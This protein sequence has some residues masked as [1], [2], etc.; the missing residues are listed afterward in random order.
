MKKLKGELFCKIHGEVFRVDEIIRSKRRS[1]DHLKLATGETISLEDKID[2][3][4]VYSINCP[5]CK[6]STSLENKDI[7]VNS[8]VKVKCSNEDCEVQI[9]YPV[10]IING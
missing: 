5:S 4:A 9:F 10:T 7:L 1:I 8:E 6:T 3:E 2:R